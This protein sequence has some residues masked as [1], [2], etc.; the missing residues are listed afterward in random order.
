MPSSSKGKEAS[1]G[2][3]TTLDNPGPNKKIVFKSP[4]PPVASG[5]RSRNSSTSGDDGSEAMEISSES[6]DS[7]ATPS[8]TKVNVPAF[9][10]SKDDWDQDCRDKEE[11]I[12]RKAQR[13]E[14]KA[15]DKKARDEVMSQRKAAGLP[16]TTKCPL[17]SEMHW[18]SDCPRLESEGKGK[19]K[20][21]PKTGKKAGGKKK[22]RIETQTPGP[23]T[24]APA[25]QPER[26][27]TVRAKRGSS[28]PTAF[29]DGTYGFL[30]IIE[31]PGPSSSPILWP[32]IVD[33]LNAGG[34]GGVETGHMSG[35]GWVVKFV[36]RKKTSSGNPAPAG[37]P[38]E[39]R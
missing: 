32:E 35:K 3:P 7:T 33:S 27:L 31:R 9:N 17:C 25:K 18:K 23:A 13:K 26:G 20:A 5:S 28:A 15:A 21:V 11:R 29:S 24:S 30:K 2:R 8:S 37:R 6:S 36:D 4:T 12:E 34:M 22:V 39:G 16:P 38:H 1:K 10:P 14:K 19:R